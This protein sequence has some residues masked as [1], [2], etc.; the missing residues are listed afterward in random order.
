MKRKISVQIKWTFL[1]L[2]IFS[3][4]SNELKIPS[5]ESSIPNTIYAL[6]RVKLSENLFFGNT[7][8]KGIVSSDYKANNISKSTIIVQD[9]VNEAAI[10]LNLNFNNERFKL[11]D[12][13]NIN[14]NNATL[15][16]TDGELTVNNLNEESLT[17]VESNNILNSKNTN[18]ASLIANAKY[19]GPILVKLDK[20]NISTGQNNKLVGELLVDD[21]IVEARVNFLNESLFAQENNPQFVQGIK[22]LARMDENGVILYPRNL[23]DIQIGLLELLEDFEVGSNTNYD[24]KLMNFSTG[25]W[26]IDGGITATSGSDPKNGKQSIRLQGTLGNNKRNG[27][28]A[29]NFDLIGIKTLNVSHGIYPAAAELAN[30]NP[31]EFTVEVSKDGGLSYTS[32]GSAEIDTKSS[33][34]GKTEFQVNAGMTEPVRIRIVN[35]SIPFANNNKPRINI[36]DIHFKF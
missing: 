16:Q 31:T 23:T 15:T 25:S 13:I 18:L 35:S 29:M 26:I 34:L 24:T 10:V 2:L 27:I 1:I 17:L 5:Y 12:L 3:G 8:I 11:G 28:I 7:A 36:D 4:C 14:L 30:V 20:I 9:P 32:I 22:G 6:R 21:E 33:S 19:W